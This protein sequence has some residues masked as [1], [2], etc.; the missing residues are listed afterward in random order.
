[1]LIGYVAMAAIAMGLGVLITKVFVGGSVERWD[2][3]LNQWFVAQRT[4]TLNPITN[5]GSELGATFTIIGI[6][7][8]ACIVLAIGRHGREL[9]FI[10]ASLVVEASVSFTTSSV[11]A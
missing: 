4:A 5:V 3:S 9:G 11:A 7:A 6:A 8:F 10:V 1:M 2:D